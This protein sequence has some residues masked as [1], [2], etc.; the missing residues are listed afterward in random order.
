M[1]EPLPASALRRPC[2][3]DQF[4]FETTAELPELPVAIGQER[5]VEAIQFGVGMR[6]E[7]YNLFAIGPPGLGKHGIVQH[8]L[9]DQ[10]ATE[11]EPSAWC[12]VHNF[13]DPQRPKALRLPRGR[14]NPFRKAMERLLDE[15][16]AAIP[17][18]LESEGFRARKRLIEEQLKRRQEQA[19]GEIDAAAKEKGIA[20]VKTASGLGLAPTRDGEVL[21]PEVFEK[22][23][24]GEQ[25]AIRSAMAD[26]QDRLQLVLGALPQWEREHRARLKELQQ[27]V[28]TQAV[29]QLIE[30]L[31]EC[32]AD[33]P[34]VLTH[35]DAVRKAV[36]E[37]ADDFLP[38]P[39]GP[40]DAGGLP[41]RAGGETPSFRKFQVNVLVDHGETR[42]AP[43]VYEDHPTHPNLLGSIE[44]LSH[45]GTLV[46][47]FNLIK[48]GALHRANGGYLIVD[49]RRILLQPYAWS[50][51]KRALRSRQIRIEPLAQSMGL[52]ST[53]TLEPEP[54]PLDLKVVFIGDRM[55]YQLLAQFDPDLR[56]LF[57]V[58]ADFE[59]RV[60]RSPEGE[61]AYAQ[62]LGSLVR[63]EGLRPL[64]RHG[65]ARVV[66]HGSRLSADSEKLSTEVEHLCD[67]VREADHFA[68]RAG[69]SAI[70]REDVEQAI[71]GR[72]R[73][74]DRIR[75]RVQE[76][77]RRGTI[78]I[79][80]DGE[81]TGQVNGLSVL[82]LGQVSFGRPNRITARVRLGTGG[83]V[84]I[85]R[86]VALGG[87]LH[88]KGVLILSGYL[89]AR[90][91]AERPLSLAASLVFEQS[92]SGVDGDSASAAELLALLS[93]LSQVPL[94]QSLAVT[95]SVDQRGR[96]QAIG[97]ANEKIEGFFDVCSSRGLTG[98][99]GV[100]IPAS[101]VKHLMLRGD[102]VQ[103]VREGAFRVYAIE[104]VDQGIEILTGQP[105]GERDAEGRFPE[106][107]VNRKVEA[108]LTIFAEKARAF[109][110]AAK[111]ENEK[112]DKPSG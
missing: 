75:Q 37:N 33:L 74:A 18:A 27:E 58:V 104:T 40:T 68:G 48:A 111:Q 30:E 47:D 69:R 66:E 10:A 4:R 70:A 39:P 8:L 108:R 16:R 100:L 9:A 96:I 51:L 57:K 82:Q 99:Q 21:G 56:D 55:L 22:L 64:D 52:V 7:G 80:T 50:E 103:A 63:K 73:R 110:K 23:A 98:R 32:H 19:F 84:D 60:D 29:E 71:E 3:P 43:V 25:E 41:K 78:L 13:D 97:G 112:T 44:H 53:V 1:I 107:C 17:A 102:V 83:V 42:G 26:L 12:Y 59:E 36:V 76:E 11:S 46:T 61:A 95:G 24:G 91:S 49:A 87:P 14:A 89:G 106:D 15:L 94:S 65:V 79:D 28:T 2:S 72:L 88:S 101:N 92:Y 45:F 109:S 67:V 6:H 31:R 77:I 20:L 38:S 35:L 105:A 85:E 90:Y 62:L 86:E 54:I 34:G 93:A 5:A 81:R